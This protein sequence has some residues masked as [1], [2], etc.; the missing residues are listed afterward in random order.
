MSN[1]LSNVSNLVNVSNSQTA[2]AKSD[3]PKDPDKYALDFLDSEITNSSSPDTKI[4]EPRSQC[5][6]ILDQL[7]KPF[8]LK[9]LTDAVKSLSNNKATGPDDIKNE[10]I[11]AT[12]DIM[13]NFYL[14]Y[15]NCIFDSGIF[16][17]PWAEGLIVPIYKKK[18]SRDDVNNYRGITLLS[19]LGKYF[20]TILNN[21]FKK[22]SDKLISNIQAGFREGFSTMD[23]VFTIVSIVNLYQKMGVNLYVAF[24]DYA[25]AFD[26]I[27]RGG[28]W[29][30]LVKEGIN[31]KFL[32]IIKNMYGEKS[33]FQN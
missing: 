1:L 27:W 2:S 26:T 32:N 11:K 28:L 15:F 16:P 8:T 10:E 4:V 5:T 9:E 12:F 30:K 33:K 20:N 22:V 3:E 18:G 24:I 29:L 17:D 23:H 31:G 19:C 14:R 21:R 25:K 6:A 13:Q 7:N